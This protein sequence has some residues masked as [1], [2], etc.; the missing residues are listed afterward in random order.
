MQKA[1]TYTPWKGQGGVTIKDGGWQPL[2]PSAIPFSDDYPHPKEMDKN[3]I[4][5]VISQFRSAA[6]R[7]I[8]AGFQLIELHF[9]HG[10]L[11]HEFLSPLSNRRKDEYGGSLENRCR[12]AIEITKSVRSAISDD[13]PLFVRI[14]SSDWVK[15]GWDIAQSV[16]LARWLKDA[17]VDLI[18]CSSGGN[19]ADARIPAGPGYQVP[20]AQRIKNEAGILTGAV[21]FVTSP[22]QAE[23][24]LRTEQSDIVLL[25]REMLR[26]PYW[27]LHAAKILNVDLK[28]P[29]QY[30]RAK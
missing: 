26:N 5:S 25:A 22:E 14:S 3:D 12:L 24:I 16:Q 15:E 19:I 17:G 29:A 20:F 2:A 6:E 27:P 4:Q 30:S 7:S 1:S 13:V 23:N 28:W 21:G 9:A 18:D 11:I 10:Y 8:K